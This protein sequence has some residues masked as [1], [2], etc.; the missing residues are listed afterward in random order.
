[1]MMSEEAAAAVTAAVVTEQQQ[2]HGGGGG[3]SSNMSLPALSQDNLEKLRKSIGV[4]EFFI[5]LIIIF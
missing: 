3:S 2:Q 4:S 1:M 5:F